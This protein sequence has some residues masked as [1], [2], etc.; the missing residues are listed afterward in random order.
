ME[1]GLSFILVVAIVS[2]GIALNSSLWVL[3]TFL[4]GCTY[5]LLRGKKKG[6]KWPL[7]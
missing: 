6:W 1:Q 5:L 2:V 7:R 3:S 4:I